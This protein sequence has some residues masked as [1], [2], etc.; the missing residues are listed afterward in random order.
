MNKY[1]IIAIAESKK[2]KMIMPFYVEGKSIQSAYSKARE[3]IKEH[4][5]KHKVEIVKIE[6]EL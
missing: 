3:Y 1:K 6:K 5:I 2:I 4:K